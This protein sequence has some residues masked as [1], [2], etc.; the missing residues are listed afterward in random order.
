[1]LK[2]LFLIHDLG[3][4]GAEKV[5]VNLVNHMDTTKFDITVMTLFDV[6]ANKQFLA[7]HIHYRS[8]FKKVFPA[9]SK[10][11]ALFSP[12]FLHRM[13]IKE[14]YDIEISY[15]EG[16]TARIISGGKHMWSSTTVPHVSTRFIGWIH[17]EQHT[18]K[19]AS[20]A[21]RSTNEAKKT[22]ELFDKLI[23]VSDTVA[24]DMQTI[25]ELK[26]KPGVLYNTVE[27]DRI[28]SESKEVVEGIKF[29]SDKINLITTG[30]LKPVKGFD[31]LLR[32]HQRICKEGYAIHL[33]ILGDGPGRE[34]LTK[35]AEDLGIADSVTFLG[36]QT[37]PYK[38]VAKCDLFVCS[39]HREGFST[40]ATEALIVGTP[41]CTTLVSGMK[42][43]LGEN[44]EYGI[45]TDNNEDGLYR[46]I[47]RLLDD[48]Q[49]LAYYKQ[50]AEKRGKAFS[51]TETVQAVEEMLLEL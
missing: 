32:I 1:M 44:G 45:I 30:T 35:Q 20:Y 36:Y 29:N 9:N 40:A 3:Q 11:L 39:S 6:G 46:G 34:A 48:S 5:L 2:V 4:G 14:Q 31:R 50:Q 19:A 16:S 28:I 23:C 17:V 15:L 18:A 38:Y 51:T 41:V 8:I 27:S 47:K 21:F 25:F 7:P 13:M 49:L 12:D 24:D 10:I 22:Y 42:E 37:N 33:Y 43:M 26:E